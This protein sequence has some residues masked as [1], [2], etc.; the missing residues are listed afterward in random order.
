[1]LL[2]FFFVK[3]HLDATLQL[4]YISGRVSYKRIS[5]VKGTMSLHF[6]M[7]LKFSSF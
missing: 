6:L 5:I 7:K 1:M 2:L 3:F 4:E